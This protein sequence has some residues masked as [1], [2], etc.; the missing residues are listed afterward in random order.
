VV[1]IGSHGDKGAHV[2]NVILP[3]AAYSEKDAIY[4]NLE[5]RPQSTSHAAFAPGKAKEDWQIFVELATKLEIDLGFKNLAQL[6]K[7][8]FAEFSIFKN[9]EKISK[10]SWQKSEEIRGEFLQ[11]KLQTQDF[12]FYLTNPIARSSRTLNKCSIELKI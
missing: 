5:G 9:L 2:A 3:A 1:Y 8:M 10:T 6:R 7:S 11:Q 4:V 12:D